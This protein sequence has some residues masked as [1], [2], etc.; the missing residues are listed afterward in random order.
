[1]PPP[2]ELRQ[3]LRV[4]TTEGGHRQRADLDLIARIQSSTFNG[5]V[6]Q[7]IQVKQVRYLYLRAYGSALSW[8]GTS[9]RSIWSGF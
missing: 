5:G 6:G 9:V 4:F 1:M 8:A 2:C 3:G 7:L